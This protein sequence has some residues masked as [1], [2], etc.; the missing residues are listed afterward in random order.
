MAGLLFASVP[1]MEEN[2][3]KLG[4]GRKMCYALYGP[5]HGNPVLYFH[6]TP[7]SRHE[8]LLLNDF[9]ID[10]EALLEQA[11]VRLIAIDRPGMGLST[12]DPRST[13]VSFAH[14]AKKVLAH[15]SVDQCPVLCWSGGGPYALAMAHE[16]PFITGVYILCGF[17]RKLDE[18]VLSQMGMNKWYFRFAKFTPLPLRLVMNFMSYCQ[19]NTTL[20]RTL[21]GLPY[22]DYAIMKDLPHLRALFNRTIRQACRTDARGPVHEANLYYKPFGFSLYH[23]R[24]PV[25]Y[26]WGTKD[27][28]V[29]R[30]HAETLEKEVPHSVMHYREHEGHL[31]VFLKCFREA[32]EAMGA[33]WQKN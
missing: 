10:A 16:F 3:I 4:N 22:V 14:D 21:T 19:I 8:I 18:E 11:N 32:L 31:S 28:S 26:W 25:H 27:M 2:I 33:L 20:P 17:S 23:I 7:S 15:L 1:H 13:I 9:G 5:A 29:I 6:G 30:L 24:Q 12:Y